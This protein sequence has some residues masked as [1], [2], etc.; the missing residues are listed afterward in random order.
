[1]ESEINY[2]GDVHIAAAR[3]AKDIQV[4]I[5][6]SLDIES[7]FIAGVDYGR[8]KEIVK[9]L[10]SD[11]KRYQYQPGSDDYAIHS[12]IFAYMHGAETLTELLFHIESIRN[13]KANND[14]LKKNVSDMDI[15]DDDRQLSLF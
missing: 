10:Q 14:G 13:R 11:E 2:G 3:Y 7:A 15:E 4:P 6:Y 8:T 9:I 12:H 5:Q 1:M